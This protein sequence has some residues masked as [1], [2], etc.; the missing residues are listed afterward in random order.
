MIAA[1]AAGGAF[2]STLR[3][4][5]SHA[6]RGLT[7]SDGWPFAT[8]TVN[9]LG[10]LVLGWVLSRSLDAGSAFASPSTRAFVVVGL[11]GGFTTF[12][13]FSAEVLAFLQA[14]QVGRA[15]AYAVASVVLAVAATMIGYSIARASA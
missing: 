5:V 13:A 1:V 14:S 8:L 15:S 3:L 6:M 2:G 10:S 11:L 9:V 12:S 4:G 7:S